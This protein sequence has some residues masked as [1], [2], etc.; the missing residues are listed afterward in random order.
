MK[1]KISFSPVQKPKI[2]GLF[3]NKWLSSETYRTS[4]LTNIR[5]K[6]FPRWN[7]EQFCSHYTYNIM[8]RVPNVTHKTQLLKPRT[9]SDIYF[10]E[11]INTTR[12]SHEPFKKFSPFS[13]WHMRIYH[14]YL[15]FISIQLTSDLQIFH[16]NAALERY[17]L[18][19]VSTKMIIQGAFIDTLMVVALAYIVEHALNQQTNQIDNHQNADQKP[20]NHNPE[21]HPIHF[22]AVNHHRPEHTTNDSTDSEVHEHQSWSHLRLP[23]QQL[24]ALLHRRK[25]VQGLQHRHY[26]CE[27][28]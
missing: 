15:R 14:N 6:I 24:I 9:S 7:F 27:V 28:P 10:K 13:T 17:V 22:P 18:P 25:T 8:E 4:K 21:K 2:I 19:K 16:L 23:L 3:T 20:T 12:K 11:K 1:V 5:E 26:A